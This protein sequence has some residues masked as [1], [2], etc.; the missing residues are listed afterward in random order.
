MD[1]KG[2]LSFEQILFC[3][4][5]ETMALCAN[6]AN[7]ADGAK[8]YNQLATDLQAK[9]VPAFW[10]DS[11]NALV[12]NRVNGTQG[13]QVTRYSNMFAIFFGYLDADKMQAVK[14]SVLL[15]DSIQKIITPY[16]RFYELEALCAMGEQKYV[17]KEIKNYWGGM[18]NAGATTFW[19]KFDPAESGTQHLAMYDRP[20]GRSLCHA[21]GASPIYLLGKYYLGVKPTSPGYQTYSIEPVLGGLQWIDGIV[22]TPDGDISVYCSTRQI[23]VKSSSGTGTLRFQSLSKPKCNSG[24]FREINNQTYELTIEKGVEYEVKY[25]Y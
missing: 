24:N 12:N 7:D 17:L 22:P 4:S 18:L 8:K 20:F 21:W 11:K 6:L 9:L 16:M 14:K 15:N 2:E 3:R 23:K 10:S 19:E 5:L 1:K 13:T 25:E